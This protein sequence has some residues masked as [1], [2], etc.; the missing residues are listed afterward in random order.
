[1][2]GGLYYIPFYLASVKNQSPIQTG[3]GLLPTTIALT[4][5]SIIIGILL[6]RT[7]RIRWALW[8]GWAFACLGYGLLIILDEKT[9]TVGWVFILIV[10]GLAQGFL[11]N[12]IMFGV[13][14]T[15]EP[16]D[17]AYAAAM[18]AFSR[19]F[20]QSIGVAIGGTVFQNLLA[21]HLQD[22]G[23]PTSI[24]KDAEG[25]VK[26]LRALPLDSVFRAQVIHAY[27]QAFHGVFGVMLG[28]AGL[29]LV[30]S[31]GVGKLSLNKPNESQH[32][33]RKK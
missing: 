14:A 22:Q 12:T 4:P 24:A 25:F 20:G 13:Q 27:V 15:S 7:G 28:I 23:L 9:P 3:V 5:T 11:L 21:K 31:L 33:L 8:S 26:T 30:L 6:T 29:G 10:V 17:V 16:Q 18:Y 32:V 1:M 2:Y 19:T